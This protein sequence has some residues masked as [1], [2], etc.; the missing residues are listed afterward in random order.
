MRCLDSHTFASQAMRR[1]GGRAL[2]GNCGRW[3]GTYFTRLFRHERLKPHGNREPCPL[4][5]S[6]SPRHHPTDHKEA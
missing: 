5:D 6:R 4:C 2:C 3:V 1:R